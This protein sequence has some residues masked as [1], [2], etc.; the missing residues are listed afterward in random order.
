M[1]SLTVFD[2]LTQIAAPL[3]LQGY[4]RAY[5]ADLTKHDRNTLAE[6]SKGDRFVWAIRECGTQLFPV[7]TGLDP[8]WLTY[9]LDKGNSSRIPTRCYQISVTRDGGAD[10]AVLSIS[11]NAARRLAAIPHPEGKVVR[12]SLFGKA[13]C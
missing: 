5:E 7:A 4:L 3:Q 6:S 9:W 11:D 10:G 2:Q 13:E 8:V 12:F 1:A